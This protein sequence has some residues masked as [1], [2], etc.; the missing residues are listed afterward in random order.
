MEWTGQRLFCDVFFHIFYFFFTIFFSGKKH[1]I[2]SF[3]PEIDLDTFSQ[4]IPI[5]FKVKF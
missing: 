3:V 5:T 2:V 4:H 1:F